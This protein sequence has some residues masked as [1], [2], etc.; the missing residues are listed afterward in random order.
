M[1]WIKSFAFKWKRTDKA[2]L[3]WM[4][5]YALLAVFYV[6]R[7]AVVLVSVSSVLIIS[8]FLWFGIYLYNNRKIL[9]DKSCSK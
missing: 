9:F 8:I 2:P 5:F 7:S 4:W 6:T 1:N 3:F